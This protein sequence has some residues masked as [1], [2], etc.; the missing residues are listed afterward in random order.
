MSTIPGLPLSGSVAA[1]RGDG[2]LCPGS[3]IC[4]AL[5][6]LSSSS[7]SAEPRRRDRACAVPILLDGFPMQN[8]RFG[9]SKV[10]RLRLR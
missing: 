3:Q 5:A 2:G 7:D 9:L 8:V 1:D 4:L 6:A 10:A